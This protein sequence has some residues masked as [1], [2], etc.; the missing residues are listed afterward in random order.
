MD[1]PTDGLVVFAKRECDTCEMVRPLLAAIPDLKIYVQDDPAWFQGD[2][3]DDSSLEA[4]F[5]RAIETVPTLIRLSGGKETAR[6]EG[7]V[8]DE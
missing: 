7:W 4:S 2:V 1:M 8:R 6:A 5:R 3:R